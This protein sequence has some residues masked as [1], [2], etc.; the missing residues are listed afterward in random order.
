MVQRMLAVQVE[1][2]HLR[3]SETSAAVLHG[4]VCEVQPH[5]VYHCWSLGDDAQQCY[6]SCGAANQDPCDLK[7]CWHSSNKLF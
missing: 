5:T 7:H 3:A 2:T 4:D 1:Y 6:S